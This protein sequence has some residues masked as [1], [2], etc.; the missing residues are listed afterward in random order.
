LKEEIDDSKNKYD[1][2][3]AKLKGLKQE[4]DVYKVKVSAYDN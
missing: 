3:M 4:L 2:I 1:N